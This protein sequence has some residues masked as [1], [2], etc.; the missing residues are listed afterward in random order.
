MTRF[1]LFAAARGRWILVAGLLVGSLAPNLAQLAKPHIG[2]MIALLLLTSC[3]RIGYR[4]AVGVLNQAWQHFGFAIVLQVATPLVFLGICLFFGFSG[5]LVIALLLMLM[6]APIAGS[7][8][9]AIM[10]GANPAPSLRQLV[11]GTAILPITVLPVLF[12]VPEFGGPLAVAKSAGSLFVII[13]A[14]A[15]IGFLIR[16]KTLPDP[17][18]KQL[19]MVD[20]VAAIL[21]AIVVVG[22]MSSVGVYLYDSPKELLSMLAIVCLANFGAQLLFGYLA[23]KTTNGDNSVAVGIASGNRNIAL[24]LTSLPAAITDP[25]LL[26]IGCYQIPMYLTPLIMDAFYRKIR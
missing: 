25:L 22:L 12:L 21:M 11:I 2:W 7:P 16:A 19:E 23:S 20:G 24:F 15:V 10:V 1:L 6:G 8:N 26:F 9:L 3:V 5:P 13:C 18:Q 14:A 4:N 17:S